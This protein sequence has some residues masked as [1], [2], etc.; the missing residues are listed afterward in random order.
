MIVMSDRFSS[1]ADL[2]AFFDAGRAA[3]FGLA[4]RSA[5]HA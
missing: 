5:N 3:A 4:A 2:S 1:L